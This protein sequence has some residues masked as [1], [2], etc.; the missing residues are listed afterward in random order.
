MVR[1][2]LLC[3]L[4]SPLFTL[5]GFQPVTVTGYN[6]D[7][8]ANG[9]G[10]ASTSIS[11]NADGG[12]PG[13]AFLTPDFKAVAGNAAPTYALPQSGL[14][15]SVNTSGLSF[16][17]ADY[18]SNN[19]LR[20][21]GTNSGT[22]SLPASVY[23]S[24]VYLLAMSGSG[25]ST[26]TITVT[27]S[28]AST[29]VFSGVSV[30]DW[31]NGAG[32]A[33]Q[34]IGRVQISNDALGVDASNPRLYELKLTIS[35]SNYSKQIS[36]ITV[37][38]TNTT[39]GVTVVVM[40][41]TVNA[42]SACVAP[43]SQP[44]G[45]N[46]TPTLYNISGSFSAASPSA[47][48]YLVLRTP[49]NASPSIQPV[50]GTTYSVG[51][52]LGNATVISASSSTSFTDATTT[53]GTTYTYTVYAYNDVSCYNAAYNTT[54]PLTATATTAS[55]AAVAGG[56]YTIGPSG[57]YTSITAAVNAIYS[58]GGATGNIILELQQSY[59][60]GVETFPLTLNDVSNGPCSIGSPTF[61]IRPAAGVAALEITSS[62]TTAT[63]DV[64]GGKKFVIDGRP[65]GAGSTKEL[66]IS[67]TSSTGVAIRF[68]ND[69]QNNVVRYCDIQGQNTTSPASGTVTSAGVVYFST[70]S[71]TTLQGNDNNTIDNCDIHSVGGPTPA[72]GIFAIG[73]TTTT[74]SYNDN[75]TISNCNIYDVFLATA[76]STAIK[77]DV[78]S[79]AWTLSNNSIYQTAPRNTTTGSITHRAFWITPNTGSISNT[80]S[81]FI[82][83]GNYIGGNLANA[84]GPPLTL[85]GSVSY[86]FQG[87]D[88]SVGSG[89]ATSVQNNVITNINETT[90]NTGNGFIGIGIANG[91]VDVGTTIGNVIGAASGSGAITISTTASAGTQWGIRLG[92]GNNLNVANNIIGAFNVGGTGA[93]STNFIGIGTGGG[94]TINVMNNTINGI[95]MSASSSATA[96]SLTGI[97]IVNG[98]T[99][100]VSGNTIQNL[101]NLYTG[102][103]AGL[104][105]G[106]VVTTSASAITNNI[107]QNLSSASA[108]TGSG[109]SCAIVGIAMSS[110][111]V[112]GCNIT[113]N[114]IDSLVLTAA[115]TTAAIQ[116]TG[117]FYL[118][119]SSALSNISRNFIHSFDATA[120]NTNVT[121][122]GIDFAVATATLANNMIRLGIK[123]DG[124]SYT[125]GSTI[126]GISSNSGSATNNFYFNSIYIGGTNVGNTSKTYAFTRTA[127]SGTYDIRD[128][129]FVND[130]SNSS[131]GTL[132][133]YAVYF[134]T[135]T[136]GVTL[137]YNI[138]RTTGTDGVFAYSGSADVANYSSGWIAGD[139]NSIAADPKFINATGTASTVNLHINSSVATM[140][141]SN[142]IL[143]AAVTDDYDAQVR[144]ALSPT[145]IG[146]DAGNF[147]QV[148]PVTLLDFNGK[149]EGGVN[150]LSWRTATET[151]NAGFLVERSADGINFS[152]I[153]SVTS[154]ANE[155]NS[156]VT[157]N[158]AFTDA[159]PFSGNNYYRLKQSDKDGKST[160]S[161][162]ILLKGE[163][164]NVLSA[165]VYPNPAERYLD[166][167]I[168]A[169]VNERVTISVITAD[170]KLMFEKYM[171]VVEG[172]NKTTL[173]ID[174]LSAGTYTVSV[175]SA[176]KTMCAY[177]FVKK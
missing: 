38:K 136:T 46:L 176:D 162:V 1:S 104:T 55:C 139:A 20:L 172:V 80:A 33:I 91:N 60:S 150:L 149:R 75:C 44:S 108:T 93:I 145:D 174:N 65:G 159:K 164:V 92:A 114:I 7:I 115:S 111:N 68:I 61:T 58:G 94:V 105:R 27:F 50:T 99:S 168:N 8:V 147:T 24:D 126:R 81:G 151:N 22:L 40:G 152:S 123:P 11:A 57:N 138:Y 132:K 35:S 32:Y 87:M 146:A 42:L 29:Q 170:G 10:S 96:Q 155:G 16:Q 71:A 158:Y 175:I 144:S 9:V 169:P 36:S 109:A 2:I 117:I 171:N 70:A 112:A 166:L 95:V 129:I 161:S 141:E 69:A 167:L 78:G 45:L 4:L 72:V 19:A 134:T 100:I 41:V 18:S 128:N 37:S 25:A 135:N 12:S 52:A 154:K 142:G 67:N 107:V 26:A 53:G 156:V 23:A 157:L 130:R 121:L 173:N 64:N 119:T 14:I 88:L 13:F 137:N 89:T 165:S 110:S 5:A 82:I 148:L 127:T 30:S 31:F 48:K 133:H 15:N 83:T 84:G 101:S 140:V 113:G 21:T 118:G 73:T 79:N 103:G 76:A 177:R 6:A 120:A 153:G 86:T 116:A 77:L 90:A 59:N 122:T 39:G 131:S 49:G 34:G 163:K 28:D 51:A 62:N 102:T 66:I 98:T 56:T 125:N 97:S 143:I 85:T 124:S 106:I 63:I 74:A 3:F 54:S 17:L 160:F 47:D 43:S